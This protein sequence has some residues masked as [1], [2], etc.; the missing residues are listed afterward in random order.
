MHE[1]HN[2][3]HFHSWIGF[4]GL[5]S[6]WLTNISSV[7]LSST[8]ATLDFEPPS[9]EVLLKQNKVH[10]KKKNSLESQVKTVKAH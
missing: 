3:A 6:Q 2:L 10:N 7:Y 8:L 5:L 1:C 9:A 4:P